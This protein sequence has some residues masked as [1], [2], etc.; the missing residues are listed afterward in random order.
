MAVRQFDAMA[1]IT[2]AF[3]LLLKNWMLAIPTAAVW[4]ITSLFFFFVIAGAVGTMGLGM[5]SDTN[6]FLGM[7]GAFFGVTGLFI[8]VI[9][10]LHIL[11]DATVVASAEGAWSGGQIDL[12]KAFSQALSSLLNLVI[13]F[14]LVGIAGGLLAITVI[15]GFAVLYFA[16][17]VLP[18]I[19]IG[20]RSAIEAIGDS[21]KL[22]IKN[23]GPTFAALGAFIVAGIAAWIVQIVVGLIPGV[24][25]IAATVVNGFLF[26]F[27][28]LVIAR[29]YDLLKGSIATA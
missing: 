29:F 8:L 14:I 9:G 28:A 21:I 6:G 27:C 23:P 4:L 16:M 1:E 19:V 18:A 22:S 25:F 3:Q 2:G 11:A 24:N 12:S 13:A 10:L 15:G 17:Y 20:K 7:L 26:G 5:A